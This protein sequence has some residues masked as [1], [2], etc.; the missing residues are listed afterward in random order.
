ML[1]GEAW[2]MVRDLLRLGVSVSEVARRTGYDRKTIRKLRD[3]PVH[4]PPLQRQRSR[5][6]DPYT[7]YLRERVAVGVLNTSKLHTELQR[8][9]YAGGVA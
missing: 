9:G 2:Y 5:I 1:Q 8:Q 7:G 4:P 6:L 3:R